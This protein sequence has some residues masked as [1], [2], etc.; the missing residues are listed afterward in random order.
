MGGTNPADELLHNRSFSTFG[1][2]KMDNFSLSNIFQTD[3]SVERLSNAFDSSGM[4]RM[5]AA[6][7]QHLQ[8]LAARNTSVSNA[9]YIRVE[10]DGNGQGLR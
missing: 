5:D 9:V 3:R 10:H 1:A 2:N 8:R 6:A 7:E 4:W